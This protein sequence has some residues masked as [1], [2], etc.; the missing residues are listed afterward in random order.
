MHVRLY[1]RSAIVSVMLVPLLVLPVWAQTTKEQKYLYTIGVLSAQGAIL[2]YTSIGA[3]A[4]GYA[5]HAYNN[6]Q[7]LHLLE[8]FV[9]T[10]SRVKESLNALMTANLVAGTDI[11]YINILS[12]AYN[13]LIAEATAFQLFIRTGD[14]AHVEVYEANRQQASN[15]IEQI[16]KLAREAR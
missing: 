7:A 15:V 5:S 16:F 2:T 3:V 10:S 1:V 11:H 9:E 8:T 6:S 4:D 14:Q 13:H 12:T